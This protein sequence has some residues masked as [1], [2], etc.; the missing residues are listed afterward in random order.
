[1]IP[2]IWKKVAFATRYGKGVSL[3]E[4]LKLSC[5]DLSSLCNALSEIV[6]EE[7]EAAKA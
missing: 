4:A 3:T 2:A 1:M 7:A 5:E 6:Q